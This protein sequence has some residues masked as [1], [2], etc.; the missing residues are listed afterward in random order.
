MELT[1]TTGYQPVKEKRKLL[2]QLKTTV[3]P[4]TTTDGKQTLFS[5][6][7]QLTTSSADA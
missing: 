1:L 4:H 3:T 2:N 5:K 7:L 6:I